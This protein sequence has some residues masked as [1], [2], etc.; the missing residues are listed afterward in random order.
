MYLEWILYPCWDVDA[1]NKRKRNEWVVT[2]H[3]YH[4][5]AAFGGFSLGATISWSSPA[6]LYIN[7]D[8]CLPNDC[9]ITGVSGDEASWIAACVSLGALTSGITTSTSL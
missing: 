7:E 3:F 1:H 8:L 5:A 4:V 6:F 2:L 9:D